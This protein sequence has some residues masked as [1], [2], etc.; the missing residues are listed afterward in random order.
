MDQDETQ[1]I[2]PPEEPLYDTWNIC[3]YAGSW[4]IIPIAESTLPEASNTNHWYAEVIHESLIAFA[5]LARIYR[6]EFELLDKQFTAEK[7]LD[8]NVKN[9]YANFIKIIRQTILTYP[10]SI[11]SLAVH[12]DLFIFCRTLQSLE[13]TVQAWIRVPSALV[14]KGSSDNSRP[15][16]C[17]EIEHTL[18]C[19]YSQHGEDN[20]ELYR[21]NQPLLER[22][23]HLWEERLGSITEFEGISGIYKYGYQVEM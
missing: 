16:I 11:Y 19:P 10:V 2:L 1:L 23:L 9:S 6:V 22:T 14:I 15:Y 18:F 5:S 3:K 4:C 21:L 17:F 12:L 8:W 20:L 13:K 7:V